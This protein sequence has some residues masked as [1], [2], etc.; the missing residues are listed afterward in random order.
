MES[1]CVGGVALGR[2]S[3]RNR[4]GEI[5]PWGRIGIAVD[6]LRGLIGTEEGPPIWM[7]AL[8]IHALL[9]RFELLNLL[10]LGLELAHVLVHSFLLRFRSPLFQ[11]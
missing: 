10:E 9:F 4:E 11:T 6:L 3:V 2:D 1:R 8:D 7:I 5:W